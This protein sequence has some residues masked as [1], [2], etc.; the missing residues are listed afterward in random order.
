[1]A[2]SCRFGSALS[3]EVCLVSTRPLVCHSLLTLEIPKAVNRT[4]NKPLRGGDFGGC[5][6]NETLT[7]EALYGTQVSIITYT[8]R[9]LRID[10]GAI[11]APTVSREN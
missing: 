8:R 9:K 10:R 6:Q 3:G 11:D 2:V 7:F 5:V 4:M 1:M